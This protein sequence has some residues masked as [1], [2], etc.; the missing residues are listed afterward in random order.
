MYA[1]T[2][3][4]TDASF[5]KPALSGRAGPAKMLAKK[6]SVRTAGHDLVI[7]VTT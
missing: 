7:S 1:S 4:S 5:A 3:G 6:L 2:R